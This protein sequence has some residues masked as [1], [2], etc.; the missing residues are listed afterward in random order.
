M[1][2]LSVSALLLPP[3]IRYKAVDYPVVFERAEKKRIKLSCQWQ[4]CSGTF[5]E[6]DYQGGFSGFQLHIE[7][8]QKYVLIL[9]FH[10]PICRFFNEVAI[11][12]KTFHWSR[13]R[14]YFGVGAL[15]LSSSLLC[16][17]PSTASQV[18]IM[19]CKTWKRNEN[20]MTKI[21][22]RQN[23]DIRYV[24]MIRASPEVIKFEMIEVCDHYSHL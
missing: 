1:P 16:R 20:K 17:Q 23:Y 3:S 5:G 6:F 4:S 9:Q 7:L 10:I 22:T 2:S 8:N 13:S 15:R 14:L 19:G 18:S 24:R 12:I 11:Q 21:E